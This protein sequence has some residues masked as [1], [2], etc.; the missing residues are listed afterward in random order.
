MLTLHGKQ[1]MMKIQKA[2]TNGVPRRLRPLELQSKNLQAYRAYVATH[3]H[4]QEQ[5]RH[6]RRG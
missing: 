5:C 6:F 1:Q 4:V 3:L 2:P